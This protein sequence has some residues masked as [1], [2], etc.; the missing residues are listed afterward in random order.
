MSNIEWTERTWQVTAGCTKVSS[1]CAHCYAETMANRLAGMARADQAAGR[2]PKGKA[3]YLHVLN[4]A[5]RWNGELRL[6]H[7]RLTEPLKWKKPTTV[8]VNSMSDLFHEAVPFEFVDKVWAVMA[9]CPQHTFQ[10]LTKR[11]ERMAEYLARTGKSIAHIDIA[12]RSLGYTVMY[13]GHGMIRWPLP[14][15]WL[16][17]SVEDQ[18]AADERIPHLLRCP[19]AVRFLSCEPL[20]G[21]VD[22]TKSL[23]WRSAF[24]CLSEDP[25][26]SAIDNLCRCGLHWVIV[27]G[28]SGPNARPCSVDW[29]RAVVQQ[30]KAAGVPCFV[31]QLGAYVLDPVA[32]GPDY[33]EWPTETLHDPEREA[34]GWR[35]RLRDRKGG[36][37]DEW[38]GDLRVREMPKAVQ[39]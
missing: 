2:E 38:P 23:G 3:P 17:T 13:E 1:G 22:L 4:D 33:E 9:L 14:N 18:K 10:V 20:L 28:E 19:A 11:P 12:A 31:K 36:T 39:S 5:G 16:G 35:M 34:G 7:D 8:F 29:I 6:L 30:C 24:G 37:P 32:G 26:A 25:A 27:G 15:V 21:P